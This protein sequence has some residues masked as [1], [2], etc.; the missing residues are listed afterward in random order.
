MDVA[1]VGAGRAGTAVAVILQ[2]AGHRIVAASGREAARRRVARYL[3]GVPVVDPDDAARGADLVVVA[4]PDDDI[5]SVVERLAAAA[6][7]RTGAWAVHLAGAL[8]LD[9][10][11]P[12]RRAGAHRL[13]MH[14]LQT[15]P[16]VDAGLER[17]P[18]CTVAVTADDRDGI[19]LGLALS[20]DLG[21][22]SF[23]LADE[24][25]PLY[26]AAAVFASNHLVVT[27]AAAARLF[28]A[29]GVPDPAAAMHPLQVA[30]LDNVARL[31]PE[32]ALTGPA[33]R[34]DA[35]TVARNLDALATSLPSAVPAYVAMARLALDIGST[36][37]RLGQ[38][39]RSAVEEALARWS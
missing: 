19:A 17:L 16:D 32:E 5:A 33:V 28:A 8:G 29:A 7:F 37:G 31:G 38:R 35:G 14:P 20:R 25:R 26:H 22:D 3:P 12:A 18:G 13:A 10:L 1:V 23:V 2:R 21:A 36:T 39:E 27:S 24:L 34:G 4:V 6:A 15:F 9:V 11:S 30:S